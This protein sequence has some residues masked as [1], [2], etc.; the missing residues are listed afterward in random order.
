MVIFYEPPVAVGFLV[1]PTVTS[2]TAAAT[3]VIEPYLATGV[4]LAMAAVTPAPVA[5]VTVAA[6]STLAANGSG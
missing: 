2:V 4:T 6:L 3:A 1:Q 5:A